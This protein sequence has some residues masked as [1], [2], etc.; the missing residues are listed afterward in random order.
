MKKLLPLLFV[1]AFVI[2]PHT[3]AADAKISI[4]SL[5]DYNVTWTSPSKDSW[6]SMPLGN[7]DI[8]LNVW[9]E[10]DGE[11]LFYISKT[12]AYSGIGR[13]LKLGRVRV[14]LTPN[15]FEKGLPFEQTLRLRQ[16]RIEFIAG[17]KGEEV[18]IKLWVDA[19]RPV[20]HVDVDSHKPLSVDAKYESWREKP[21]HITSKAEQDSARG[22]TSG[23]IPFLV[24]ADT[25]VDEKAERI[26]FYHRNNTSI[27]PPTLK[28][29]ALGHLAKPENDPLLHRTFGGLLKGKGFAKVDKTTL[30]SAQPARRHGFSIT[31][32]TA[33]TKTA[34]QW[35][36][37]IEELTAQCEKTDQKTDATE[38][39]KWWGEFWGRSHVF[40]SPS[41]AIKDGKKRKRP[42][43]V[44][45]GYILQR[46]ISAC[47]GRGAMPI[48]F[49]GSIFTVDAIVGKEKFDADYRR[50]GGGYWLQ[51]T[52]LPYWAML[53]SGDFEMMRPFFEM[54]IKALP[55]AKQRA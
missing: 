10:A 50:W 37:G 5:D 1:S 54:Y 17:K 9:A 42:F 53:E 11:L 19:N 3:K 16:G 23:E 34:K 33:I 44:T 52:R 18:R 35:M 28:L 20:I 55:L 26:V 48:K 47:S 13:L 21:R 12:D 36:D 6:G 32:K 24:E 22:I 39:E 43:T 8:G 49:N 51:N 7:G 30:R 29:Q 41:D 40:V 46:F 38:H 45:R 27:W 15:P 2:S 14:K 25:I 4:P 31:V